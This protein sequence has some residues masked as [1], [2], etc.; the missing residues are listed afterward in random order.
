MGQVIANA[1]MSLDGYIAKD[2]NTI[3]RLFDWLQNGDNEVT[4]ASP[5]IT[6]HLGDA[7]TTYWQRWVSSLG[8]LV[9]G[10]RKITDAMMLVAAETLAGCVTDEDLEA[11]RVCPSLSRIRSVSLKIAVAVAAE[12]WRAGLADNPRP[13]DI[14]T[15]IATRMFDPVYREYA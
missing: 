2:D 7:S 10:A 8:A 15:H 12:A 13:D 9:C 6:F 4:T 1:S 14:E 3:G 11:G 5:G